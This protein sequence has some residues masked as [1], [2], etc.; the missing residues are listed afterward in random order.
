MSAEV[1]PSKSDTVPENLTEI[2]KE[3]LSLVRTSFHTNT[4]SKLI[5]R[6]YWGDLSESLR[7]YMKPIYIEGAKRGYGHLEFHRVEP[8]KSS[9]WTEGGSKVKANLPVKWTLVVYGKDSD[10]NISYSSEFKLG[11][12]DSRIYFTLSMA[13]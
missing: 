3:F 10:S 12:H 6:I 2:E 11:E 13:Q 9:T 4:P 1:K 7:E 5:D 8:E